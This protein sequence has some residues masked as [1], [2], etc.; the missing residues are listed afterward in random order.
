M[1]KEDF[2][3]IKDMR[4][5]IICSHYNYLKHKKHK[6]YNNA[7]FYSVVPIRPYTIEQDLCSYVIG[8]TFDLIIIDYDIDIPDN[9][10]REILEPTLFIRQGLIEDRIMW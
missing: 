5:M 3:N 10:V 9:I 7:Q 4:I 1:K 8:Q 2:M 6:H